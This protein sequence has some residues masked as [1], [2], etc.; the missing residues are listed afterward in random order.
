MVASL[1]RSIARRDLTP[2][3]SI[4]ELPEDAIEDETLIKGG[5]TTSTEL[6]RRRK[7]GLNELPLLVG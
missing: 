1:V 3:G 2:G 4:L 7:K 5:T 6:R